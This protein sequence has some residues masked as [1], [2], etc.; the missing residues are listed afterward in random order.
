[1]EILFALGVIVAFLIGMC[2]QGGL[3]INVN[4]HKGQ[5]LELPT[6]EEG[7]PKYNQS[8]DN[9]TAEQQEYFR[10]NSGQYRI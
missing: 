1:M 9:L 7:N 10:K 8:S 2:V 4:V 6:D 5:D 3:N